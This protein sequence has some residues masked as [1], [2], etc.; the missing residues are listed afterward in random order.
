MARSA[1]WSEA[2]SASCISPSSS[3]RTV[4]C[5]DEA[6]GAA[7][8]HVGAELERVAQPLASDAQ[9][10]EV[11]HHAGPLGR[12][13]RLGHLAVTR[14]RP[15][16][17]GRPRPGPAWPATDGPGPAGPWRSVPWPGDPS[18]PS[19]ARQQVG[20]GGLAFA[21]EQAQ[22]DRPADR[23]RR[24]RCPRSRRRSA[25]PCP[26]APRCCTSRSRTAPRRRASQPSSSRK[27]WAR[28]GRT[29]AKRARAARRRRVA[30]RMS[31]SSSRS[32]PSRVPGSLSRST[33]SW[34]RSTA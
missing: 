31:W 9:A 27:T 10:V 20:P 22:R 14:Q 19:R 4:S 23:G 33:A 30:T 18:G 26:P 11:G 1:S 8:V 5:A 12:L 32:S 2:T 24:G 21:L 13:G 29:S 15:A 28:T 16:R 3:C 17:A 7:A 6:D 25:P 34:R